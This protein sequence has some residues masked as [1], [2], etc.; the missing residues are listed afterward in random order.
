MEAVMT[1]FLVVLLVLLC[2]GLLV[3]LVALFVLVGVVRRDRDLI[4]KIAERRL[5]LLAQVAEE[6]PSTRSRIAAGL[7]DDVVKAVS[8]AV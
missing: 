7:V 3:L 1:T 4:C 8:E 5:D 6:F 2:A